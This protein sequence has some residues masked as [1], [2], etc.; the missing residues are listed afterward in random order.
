MLNNPKLRTWSDV[1]I[2]KLCMV[3]HPFV[4]KLRREYLGEPN[5]ENVAHSSNHVI[6]RELDQKLERTVALIRKLKTRGVALDERLLGVLEAA[7][8]YF[9][10]AQQRS[11]TT[12][13]EAPAEDKAA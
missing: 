13:W 3:T 2:A 4:G 5:P 10:E 6:L 9:G 11:S 1:D 8:K 7:E 12:C